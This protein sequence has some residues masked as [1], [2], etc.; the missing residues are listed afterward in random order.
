MHSLTWIYL[1]KANK[2]LFYQWTSYIMKILKNIFVW[3]VECE[4]GKSQGFVATQHIYH[5]VN[6]FSLSGITWHLSW[7]LNVYLLLHKMKYNK[8]D[9]S[10]MSQADICGLSGT[11]YHVFLP[12]CLHEL[13]M[14]PY[15]DMSKMVWRLTAN[16]D[17]I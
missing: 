14:T 16:T 15:L 17:L 13:L 9:A 12:R 2:K 10:M 5:H 6:Y 7:I 11:I 3:K 4:S 8:T 1:G